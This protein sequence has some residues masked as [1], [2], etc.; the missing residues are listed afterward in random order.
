[1][2]EPSFPHP[3]TRVGR[4]GT[5]ALIAAA[6]ALCLGLAASPSALWRRATGQAGVLTV[7]HCFAAHPTAKRADWTCG[8]SFAP[9]DGGA[10]RIVSV[11]ADDELGAGDRVDADASNASATEVHLRESPLAGLLL[12]PLT[13][14]AM[15]MVGILRR[16]R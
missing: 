9:S 4:L 12:C 15:L 3:V 1:M 10:P 7:Q 16:R 14:L 5:A 11:R 8:G 13:L 6:L 2:T